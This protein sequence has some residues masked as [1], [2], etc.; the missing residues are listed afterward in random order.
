[1][2]TSMA[3]QR[4]SPRQ[5]AQIFRMD[6]PDRYDYFIREV[7]ASQQVWGLDEEGWALGADNNGK[8]TFPL[9]PAKELAAACASGPWQGFEPAEITLEDLIEELLPMLKKDG[10]LPSLVRSPDGRSVLAD[11]DQILEDL[12]QEL[13]AT[14]P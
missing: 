1:M 12:Y 9:W 2:V 13:E 3:T 10:V 4:L 14:G 6:G 7:V 5:V 8:A 11:V